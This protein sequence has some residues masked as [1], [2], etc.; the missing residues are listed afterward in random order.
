MD[1]EIITKAY[2]ELPSVIKDAIKDSKWEGGLR[3]I[4]DKYNLRIDQAGSIENNAV[5]V[6]IGLMSVT[7]FVDTIK[8]E[9]GITNKDEVENLV[10][11]VEKEIFSKIR[12]AVIEQ[13]EKP[14][15][16]V[17]PKTKQAKEENIES[18]TDIMKEIEDDEVIAVEVEGEEDEILSLRFGS[19]STEEPEEK[20]INDLDTGYNKDPY[21]EAI[22][23]E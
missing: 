2:N 21:R 9:S 8:S 23:L 12:Q 10:A 17:T 1:Q 20:K 19:S 18:R 3:R 7:D 16:E 14:K 4:L 6:M 11:D 15:S 22:D 13:A 5:L